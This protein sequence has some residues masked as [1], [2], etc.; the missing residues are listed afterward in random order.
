MKP[1]ATLTCLLLL[2]LQMGCTA[3]RPEFN[4]V[5]SG[6]D[7]SKASSLS[8]HH[9]R[10]KWQ[11]AEEKT[12]DW[13][14]DLLIAHQ[15]LANIIEQHRESIPLWR[16]HRR[17]A[18]DIAGHQFSFIFY[19]PKETRVLIQQAIDSHPVVGSLLENQRLDKAWITTPKHSSRLSATSDANWPKKLQST[20]PAFIMGVSQTWLGL[21][22]S[23]VKT[24]S[25]AN[26]N[27]EKKIKRYRQVSDK[28]NELWAEYAQ[29]AFFH[30][31]SGVFGYEPL[32]MRKRLRF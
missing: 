32:I 4:T 16:F 15:V 22:E 21:I 29:H 20:W 10:F 27:M 31:I 12:P 18:P 3:S 9:L 19:S 23:H 26:L 8:W 17:A 25:V 2:L 5:V 6:M 1:I 30:H 14:L 11:W 28:L 7:T 24:A 13:H